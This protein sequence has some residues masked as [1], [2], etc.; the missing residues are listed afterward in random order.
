MTVSKEIV[1]TCENTS[2]H[3]IDLCNF[4]LN[5][6]LRL[7]AILELRS[8]TAAAARMQSSQ[9]A[10]SRSFGLLRTI[11]RDDLL[12]RTPSGYAVTEIGEYLLTKL[13]EIMSR[14]CNILTPVNLKPEEM[15]TQA[16]VAMPDHQVL[17]LAPRLLPYLRLHAPNLDIRIQPSLDHSLMRLESGEIDFAI[18]QVDAIP[19][20]FYQR[21]LY[22]DRFVCL[23]RRDHPFRR[24]AWTEERFAALRHVVIAPVFED[25]FGSIHDRLAKLAPADRT[26]LIVPDMMAAPMMVANTDLALVVPHRVAMHAISML[27]LVAMELPVKQPAYDVSLFWH[28]RCH[29]DAEQSWIRAKVATAVIAIAS[30]GEQAAKVRGLVPPID[31][32]ALLALNTRV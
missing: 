23:L 15:R 24:Q 28:K 32:G 31:A 14:I 7:E 2:M 18:G 25:G 8:I 30:R 11:F 3:G 12:V 26:P 21:R 4:D 10:M 13:P 5:L 19:R 6:L 29:R 17:A 16:A 27:P 20:R 1:S 22:S 9:S